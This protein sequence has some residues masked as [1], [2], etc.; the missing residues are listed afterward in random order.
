VRVQQVLIDFTALFGQLNTAINDANT[1]KTP[2]AITV[3][4]SKLVAIANAGYVFAFPQSA[5]GF[6]P[7][8]LAVLVSQGKSLQQRFAGVIAQY[9]SQLAI[10]E[11]V[12][13][14]PP[15]QVS[16]LTEM[17]QLM[18]GADFVLMPRFSFA[19]VADVAQAFANKKQIVDYATNTLQIPLLTDEWLHG[20]SQVRPKMQTFEMVRLLNDTYN[21]T[22]ID[23]APIQLPYKDKDAWLAVEFPKD[24]TIDH[25]TLSIVQYVPQGFNASKEQIGLLLDE[26][27]ESIPNKE[28]VTGISFNYNQPN[29]VPPQAI[30]LAVTPV[31][32]G[33]WTWNDLTDSILETFSRAKERAIEPDHID[34]MNIPSTLLPAILSEF[35]TSRTNLSLDFSLNIAAVLSSVMALELNKS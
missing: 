24:T 14:K 11:D 25:D 6:A 19:D 17:L 20:V 3:L 32:T 2:A 5:I 15:Q 22:L 35:S 4:R 12:N 10:V 7:E 18:L 1:L 8:Q 26:W 31:E 30:L 9:N 33:H 34:Q 16:L 23:L 28:E 21:I 29:S 27:T 13:T